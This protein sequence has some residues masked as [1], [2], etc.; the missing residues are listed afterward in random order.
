[1]PFTTWSSADLITAA[2]LNNDNTV[3]MGTDTARTVTVTHTYTLTQTFTG[4]WTSAAAATITTAS[5][6]AFAVG[7]RVQALEPL[8]EGLIEMPAR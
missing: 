5:A 1:M 7:F 8:R 6:T 2:K 3:A 4:G